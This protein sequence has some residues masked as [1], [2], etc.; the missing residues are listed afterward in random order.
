MLHLQI[1]AHA[2][3]PVYRQV[4]DQ[5][6]YYIASGILKPGDRLPSIRELAQTLA[7]NPT[8]V[9]RV[10]GDLEHEGVIEMQHGRGAFVTARSFRMTSA[11]RE[12]KIRELAR[13]LVVEAAQMGVPAS[14][15]LKAV[16]EELEELQE[17]EESE[18]PL[19]LPRLA[20]AS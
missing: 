3:M 18:P 17:P 10:Y 13:R 19:R 4:L 8:T 20:R 14:Q 15:V 7:I 12:R 16:Q 11:Q 5:I 6:K 9:V 2:G 1:D